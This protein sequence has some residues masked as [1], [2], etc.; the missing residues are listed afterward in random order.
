M[1]IPFERGPQGAVTTP[2][3]QILN[4][5]GAQLDDERRRQEAIR[6]SQALA[7][8]ERLGPEAFSADQTPLEVIMAG[9]EAQAAFTQAR[10][11]APLTEPVQIAPAPTAPAVSQP[12]PQPALAP[13]ATTAIDPR[14]G[15]PVVF[16]ENTVTSTR[17]L[18]RLFDNPGQPTLIG[19]RLVQMRG[20]GTLEILNQPGAPPDSPVPTQ[21][22]AAAS[23][24]AARLS[25][26]TSGRPAV[27]QAANRLQGQTG[28][29]PMQAG[30][31][32]TLGQLIIQGARL[33]LRRGAPALKR[34]PKPQ[35]PKP[36]GG[37]TGKQVDRARRGLGAA[38]AL[39]NEEER[40]RR[41]KSDEGQKFITSSVSE[42]QREIDSVLKSRGNSVGIVF[43][44]E[45]GPITINWGKE[46]NPEKSFR[47]G[48]GLSKI[49]ARRNQQ[50]DNG[51]IDISGNDFVRNRLANVLA[52]GQIKRSKN[53]QRVTIT[54]DGDVAILSLFRFED[55]E[56]W[57]L[58][59]F[60]PF[61]NN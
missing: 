12:T 21:P 15:A 30:A 50:F 10:Q 61:T 32:G 59:A 13:R 4:G 52:N 25:N 58:N 31:L 1:P 46:G 45:L 18:G 48:E 35:A 38:D 36:P 44:K 55:K 37:I 57:L 34:L 60:P 51:E 9:P 54:L 43:R 27:T 19:D 29:E 47:G 56:V 42:F 23:S 41:E 16:D 49:I 11:A 17:E 8:V 2:L 33:L 24:A 6:Q 5:I 39:S 3:D 53:G 28:T 20:D 26:R 40:K 14:T 7:L 22:Q